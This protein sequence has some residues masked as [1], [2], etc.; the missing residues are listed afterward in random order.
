M[1]V[2]MGIQKA[3]LLK[4]S[5]SF[6]LGKHWLI[7]SLFNDKIFPIYGIYTYVYVCVCICVVVCVC[8][9]VS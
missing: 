6:N 3:I 1:I 8:V 9:C 2:C 5:V 4:I 7:Q